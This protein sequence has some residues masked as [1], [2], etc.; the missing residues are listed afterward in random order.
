MDFAEEFGPG[1]RMLLRPEL[2]LGPDCQLSLTLD[3]L[4][5][6]QVFCTGRSSWLI[7]IA[8]AGTSRKA[9]KRF[10]DSRRHGCSQFGPQSANLTS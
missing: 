7:A 8:D 1:L 4:L 6:E 9:Q 10:R 2:A 3:A 5:P